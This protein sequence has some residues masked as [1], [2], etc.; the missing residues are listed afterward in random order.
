M[1]FISYIRYFY[2]LLDNW[3]FKIAWYIIREE[4]RGE[5]K[6]RINSTG[7]DE[8]FDLEALGVDV[9]H[10]AIYMPVNF[11][12]LEEVFNHLEAV[13]PS[14]PQTRDHFLDLGCGKGR[15]L[16]MAAHHG[17]KQLSGIDFSK[18]LC[19]IANQNLALVQTR[20]PGI[21]YKIINNDAFYYDIPADV[22]CIFLFNPFDEVIMSAVVNNI[23]SSLEKNP[24]KISI[25]YVN[26]VHKDLFIKAG[27]NEAWH[28]Q[29]LK[30]LEAVILKN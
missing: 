12:L 27:Y 24:R 22:N 15:A 8:L 18:K 5:R 4:I 11:G 26:P 19:G 1:K 6:Y 17:F 13:A 30:Y 3:D 20:F 10:A 9:S 2:F 7:A 28:F 16:C 23:F 14:N 29:K 21:T 25:I